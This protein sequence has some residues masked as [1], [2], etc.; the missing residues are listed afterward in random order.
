MILVVIVEDV[1]LKVVFVLDFAVFVLEL[2]L[3]GDQVLFDFGEDLECREI[4]Q[5]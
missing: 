1:P 4:E 5:N 3:D 2:D